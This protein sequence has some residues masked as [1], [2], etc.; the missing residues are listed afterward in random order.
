MLDTSRHLFH[1]QPLNVFL[2]LF[3]IFPPPTIF[4]FGPL[5]SSSLIFLFSFLALSRHLADYSLTSSSASFHIYALL[6]LRPTCAA[7]RLRQPVS[8][9]G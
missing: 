3:V 4:S 1:G 9:L 7:S 2:L 5:F 6:A 8:P